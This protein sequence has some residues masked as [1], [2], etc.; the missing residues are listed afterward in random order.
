MDDLP[1]NIQKPGIYN[2]CSTLDIDKIESH[3]RNIWYGGITYICSPPQLKQGLI[4]P[5]NGLGDSF[6]FNSFVWSQ[7]Y[8]TTL[9][10]TMPF[11]R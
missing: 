11:V 1:F 8:S 5:P 9:V 2:C 6:E 3:F 7:N 4:E 10:K